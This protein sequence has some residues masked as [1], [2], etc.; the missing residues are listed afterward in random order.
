M[1]KTKTVLGTMA[2]VLKCQIKGDVISGSDMQVLFDSVKFSDPVSA[3]G[4][5]ESVSVTFTVYFYLQT[6]GAQ[7]RLSS[8]YAVTKIESEVK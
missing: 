1:T 4:T 7:F 3:I 5:I 6:G 8:L 2:H